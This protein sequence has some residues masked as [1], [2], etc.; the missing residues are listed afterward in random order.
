MFPYPL[1]FIFFCPFYANYNVETGKRK[2]LDNG[3]IVNI[4][5]TKGK[6]KQISY[7]DFFAGKA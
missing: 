7:R 1:P 3:D 6:C 5:S 2:L 4:L